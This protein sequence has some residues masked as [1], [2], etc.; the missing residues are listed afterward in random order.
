MCC[1]LLAGALLFT[2]CGNVQ[3]SVT[4]ESQSGNEN[5]T[6]ASA[7]TTNKS[8]EENSRSRVRK[9]D[10][11][12]DTAASAAAENMREGTD[13]S[14]M[15]YEHYDPSKVEEMMEELKSLMTDAANGE[16][17]AALFRQLEDEEYNMA[18]SYEL[19][20]LHSYLDVTDDYYS[21]EYTYISDLY[22][23]IDD[24][25]GI[26]GNEL[27]SS[28]CGE[29]IR[30]DMT[31]EEILYYEGYEA[32]TE[33]QRELFQKET[34]LI[35][36]YYESFAQDFTVTVN[37]RE[38]TADELY[39][40]EELSYEE[41]EDA[42]L[43]L[44]QKENAALGPI[45][46]E[47]VKVRSRIA[48]SYGYDTYTEYAYEVTYARDYSPEDA[49]YLSYDV[50]D[51]LLDT[52]FEY[53]DAYD[54]DAGY[55][56]DGLFDEMTIEEQMEIAESYLIDVDADMLESFEFMKTY[57]LYDLEYSDTKYEGGFTTWIDVYDEPFLFNQPGSGFYDYMTL[58]H[59]FGHYNAYYVNT[60]NEE[61]WNNIDLAEIHSQ[62]LE[63][64][65]CAFYEEMLGEEMGEAAVN[66]SMLQLIGAI[67]DGCM[68]DEFQQA[69]YAMEDPTLEKINEA[70]REVA[71]YYG[72]VY[73]SPE[74]AVDWIAVPHN[75]DQP[76]YYISYAV[77]ALPALEIYAMAE[78]DFA[79]ACRV[80]KALVAKGEAPSF[81][82]TLAECGLTDPF[83]EDYIEKLAGEM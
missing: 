54:A 43:E 42:Y 60:D 68:Y 5:K 47:L 38:Y 62:G 56:L 16:E 77:S 72:Y 19:A 36:E 80:Y 6:G 53:Y 24:E 65:Y 64:L 30:A 1:L 75:F 78:E 79:E 76:L 82:D 63:M 26:L 57:H 59:E 9:N 21:D 70:F 41:Y 20:D 17:A 46:V 40:D 10:S 12:D 69:V 49:A 67:L 34:E 31:E 23:V 18:L 52:Y 83:E 4:S 3:K 29:A 39:Y 2:A 27:L 7:E 81:E 44:M 25:I 55:T 35:E 61:S 22:N 32:M 28:P 74:E 45:F 50:S 71:Q 51:Y 37:G 14:D 15:V 48:A 33:E 8:G 13:F 58:V 11:W 66:Y 73:D